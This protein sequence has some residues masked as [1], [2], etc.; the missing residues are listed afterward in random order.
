MK[1]KL[2][3]LPEG[4]GVQFGNYRQHFKTLAMFPISPV[5]WMDEYLVTVRYHQW[6]NVGALKRL[7]P[8][9]S[10]LTR[11]ILR[12]SRRAF[13]FD[14]YWISS[15]GVRICV[16]FGAPERRHQSCTLNYGSSGQLI[17]VSNFQQSIQAGLNSNGLFMVSWYECR[18]TLMHPF[19][20]HHWRCL[21]AHK[22][23][24]LVFYLI[25]APVSWQMY[26]VFFIFSLPSVNHQCSGISFIFSS[27][28]CRTGKHV[29]KII[30]KLS[31]PTE[32]CRVNRRER[33]LLQVHMRQRAWKHHAC[34]DVYDPVNV[35]PD[36]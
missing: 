3:I 18:N 29:V 15:N 20:C 28:V 6:P 31:L 5:S 33:C 11:W 34:P 2:N 36:Q 9:F 4:V 17:W 14:V 10:T 24:T 27:P 13:A 32:K 30:S 16:V 12:D 35:L 1:P 22:P 23:D 26:T 19:V 21:T 7:Y 25:V 8:W